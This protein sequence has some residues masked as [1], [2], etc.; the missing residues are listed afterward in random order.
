MANNND[1]KKL[2]YADKNRSKV[3]KLLD[4]DPAGVK[5]IIANTVEAK[6]LAEKLHSIE[7]IFNKARRNVGQS[8]PIEKFS[9]ITGKFAKVTEAVDDLLIEAESLNMYEPYKTKVNQQSLLATHRESIEKMLKG[10]KDEKEIA[11]EIKESLFQTKKL[12][13]LIENKETNENTT[14]VVEDKT[15]TDTPAAKKKTV[16]KQ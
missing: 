12:I 1:E 15:T 8:L 2:S 10:K 4:K 13:K 3:Q 6:M 5:A 9:L 11:L 7:Y 14:T 16:T